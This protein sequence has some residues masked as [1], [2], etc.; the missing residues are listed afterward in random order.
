[1]VFKHIKRLSTSQ[2][3]KYKLEVYKDYIFMCK[4]GKDKKELIT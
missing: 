1:M 2:F 3:K 4:I